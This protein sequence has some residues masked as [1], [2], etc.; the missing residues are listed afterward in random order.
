MNPDMWLKILLEPSLVK[1]PC[2]ALETQQYL[3]KCQAGTGLKGGCV[4]VCTRTQGH[5]GTWST[6][7]QG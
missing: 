4:C 7:R 3:V 2:H 5:V 6:V 1:T